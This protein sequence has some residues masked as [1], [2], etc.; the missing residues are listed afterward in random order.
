MEQGI[1]W[2]SEAEL[3][4]RMVRKSYGVQ[5]NNGPT[6]HNRRRHCKVPG[7]LGPLISLLATA[8][9]ADNLRQMN[10]DWVK[11]GSEIAIENYFAKIIKAVAMEELVAIA[12]QGALQILRETLCD[13]FRDAV[14][15]QVMRGVLSATA[16]NISNII[17]VLN[18]GVKTFTLGLIAQLAFDGLSYFSTEREK[19]PEI[20]IYIKNKVF[21]AVVTGIIGS[22]IVVITPAHLGLLGV[23]LGTIASGIITAF[24]AAQEHASYSTGQP[25]WKIIMEAPFRAVS[26]IFALAPAPKEDLEWHGDNLDDEDIP[27]DMCCPITHALFVDPVVLKGQIY[28]RRAV[29]EW[30]EMKGTHPLDNSMVVTVD[31]LHYCQRMAGLVSRFA[32]ER[33]LALVPA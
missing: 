18:E 8:L 13:H 24:L 23:A 7:R 27:R 31:D 26:S 10:R 21:S 12:F 17:R 29:L 16:L 19:R 28:E 14:R 22:M 33:D 9:S 30:I 3:I 25:L 5:G 32:A 20:G 2:G 15:D 6:L 4:G 11:L 1:D